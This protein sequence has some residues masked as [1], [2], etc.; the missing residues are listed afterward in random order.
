MKLR[1]TN[2]NLFK[3]QKKNFIF[4]FCFSC[5]DKFSGRNIR[6]KLCGRRPA[7][8]GKNSRK[9]NNFGCDFRF[10]NIRLCPNSYEISGK[11]APIRNNFG[12]DFGFISNLYL[13]VLGRVLKAFSSHWNIQILIR[14]DFQNMLQL[15]IGSSPSIV[16][17]VYLP[18]FLFKFV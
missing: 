18:K 12:D 11:I 17:L 6:K 16:W 8:V 10:K 1:P 15:S 13:I 2:R 3:S 4:R 7:S 9:C 5:V 14:N